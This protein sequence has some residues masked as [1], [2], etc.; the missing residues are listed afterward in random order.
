MLGAAVLPQSFWVLGGGVAIVVLAL[1]VFL[2]RTMHGKAVLA[3][4]ANRLAAQLVGINTAHHHDARLR[5]LGRH[6]RACRHSHHADH[7][8]ELRCRHAAR[9][10]GLCRGDARRHGQSRS[11]RSSAGCCSACS[12]AFSA[13]YLSSA[14]K[15]AV[16]F[17]VIL[18]VL[19]AMPQRPVRAPYGGAGVEMRTLANQRFAHARS[20]WRS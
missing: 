17:L 9:A 15:D 12:R 10:E 2:E 14:Y 11:G 19:F 6:R 16:A 4:A 5:C 20:S 1:Y 13:G 3:T 7:A 18:V 8:D